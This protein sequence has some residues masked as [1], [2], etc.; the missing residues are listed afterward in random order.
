MGPFLS[1]QPN[2]RREVN[3]FF[4]QT[5]LLQAGQALQGQGIGTVV[6][7]A[8]YSTRMGC[9]Y[10]GVASWARGGKANSIDLPYL[11][12]TSLGA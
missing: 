12:M 5:E 7:H 6:V 2:R 9:E 4:D 1:E 10:F 8:G 11:S 3:A